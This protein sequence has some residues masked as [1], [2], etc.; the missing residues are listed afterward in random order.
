MTWFYTAIKLIVEY[1]Q[2]IE[3]T[4]NKI[5]NKTKN[6]NYNNTKIYQNGCKTFLNIIIIIAGYSPEEETAISLLG[7][8]RA[9]AGVR[10][11]DNFPAS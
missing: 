5:Q 11:G 1:T 9:R 2:K 3:K 8:V 7:S 6:E 4:K 10:R